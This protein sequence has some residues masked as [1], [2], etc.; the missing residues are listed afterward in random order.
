MNIS[1]RSH[2]IFLRFKPTY[3]YILTPGTVPWYGT[4]WYRYRGTV[5]K[6][7]QKK[8]ISK[9]SFIIRH[10]NCG[11]IF[12]KKKFFFVSKIRLQNSS[13]KSYKECSHASWCKSDFSIRTSSSRVDNINLLIIHP[14][15]SMQYYIKG[16]RHHH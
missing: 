3:F 6:R 15:S 8:M 2:W 9:T 5:S 14:C 7:L 1:I 11:D 10:K 4:K 16:T 12:P 13:P